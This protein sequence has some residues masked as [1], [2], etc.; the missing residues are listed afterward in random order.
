MEQKI[1]LLCLHKR[2][3]GKKHV[4][5]MTLRIFNHADSEKQAHPTQDMP[6]VQ[7]IQRTIG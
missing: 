1:E 5:N 2:Q 3:S 6:T 7:G 4:Y